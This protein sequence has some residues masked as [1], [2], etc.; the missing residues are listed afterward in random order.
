MSNNVRRVVFEP[1][2]TRNKDR[3]LGYISDLTHFVVHHDQQ[4]HVF[5]ISRFTSL[6]L[7]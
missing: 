4:G 3:F 2:F 7:Y 1:R 6:V 5:D